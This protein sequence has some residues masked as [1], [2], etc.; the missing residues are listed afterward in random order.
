MITEVTERKYHIVQVKKQDIMYTYR[1]FGADYWEFYDYR[2]GRFT[3]IENTMSAPRL[4]G[5]YQEHILLHEQS[6]ARDCY[7]F[8]EWREQP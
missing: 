2:E 7:E 5:Q 8:K 1:R 6:N 3:Q 4:E